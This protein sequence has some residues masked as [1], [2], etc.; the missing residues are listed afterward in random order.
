MA[1]VN[2]VV[3]LPPKPPRLELDHLFYLKLFILSQIM[4]CTR[5]LV[6]IR[7]YTMHEYY[8]NE[9]MFKIILCVGPT[10]LVDHCQNIITLMPTLRRWRLTG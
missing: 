2:I 8:N 6:K 5:H 7:G 9:I 10:N 3:C 4:G 1:C